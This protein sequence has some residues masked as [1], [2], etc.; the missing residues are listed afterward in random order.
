MKIKEILIQEEKLS[1]SL[2]P[3]T[4]Q[5]LVGGFTGLG[6][7]VVAS[8]LINYALYPMHNGTE[9]KKS[10]LGKAWASVVDLIKR[11][12]YKKIGEKI[13]K[14]EVLYVANLARLDIEVLDVA[15]DERAHRVRQRDDGLLAIL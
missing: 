14:E 8:I 1:E 11:R 12:H 9:F 4:I 6:L 10:N 13:S 7:S 2:D 3:A 15:F 5:S